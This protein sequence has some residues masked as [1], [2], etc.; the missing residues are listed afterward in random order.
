M[1]TL[2]YLMK[3]EGAFRLSV[4]LGILALMLIWES[5]APRRIPHHS[6][7]K[8]GFNNIGLS[9]FNTLLI[10]LAI[11]LGAVGFAALIGQHQIGLIPFLGLPFLLGVFICVL[12]L[13]AVIYWQHRFFHVNQTL[14]RLHQVHH[15][16]PELDVTSGARFHP[17]EILLSMLIK[18]TAILLLGAPPEAVVL[19][20]IILNGMAMFNHSNIYFPVAFDKVL[21]FFVVTPDMHRIH[22]STIRKECDSNFGFN[23]SLWDYLFKSY[24]PEPQ[25]G[26]LEMD[27]GVKYLRDTKQITQIPGM[28]KI[29]F[30]KLPVNPD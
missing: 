25:L 6:R 13:D 1:E 28:L 5:L 16:D 23:L 7:V 14:W 3:H 18:F 10:R 17:I 27:I 8:R 24:T 12:I 4:F 9:L 20:E 15:A 29:P 2:D 19:F 22:H 26:Q 21:R 30:Y 11:P